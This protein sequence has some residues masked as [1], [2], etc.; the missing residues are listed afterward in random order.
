[1]NSGPPKKLSAHQQAL[2]YHNVSE[3]INYTVVVLKFLRVTSGV[4]S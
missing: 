1:M 2:L 4:G 3:R